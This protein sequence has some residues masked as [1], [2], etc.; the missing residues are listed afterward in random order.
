MPPASSPAVGRNP[1]PANSADQRPQARSPPAASPSGGRICRVAGCDARSRS[2]SARMSARRSH[3]STAPG[4]RRANHRAISR[5]SPRD[6]AD[7]VSSVRRVRSATMCVAFWSRAVRT[8]TAS[9]TPASTY[10]RPSISTGC[11]RRGRTAATRRSAPPPSCRRRRRSS[12][13][14]P[15]PRWR[16]SCRSST[17]HASCRLRRGAPRASSRRCPGVLPCCL[18]SRRS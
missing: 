18:R 16:S 6:G 4:A 3:V 8:G 13:A 11:S 17:R 1:S 14:A 10:A 12:A 9:L 15:V 2:S 5:R 7:A